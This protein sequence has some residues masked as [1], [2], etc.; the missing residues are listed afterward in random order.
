MAESAPAAAA[1]P[2][3]KK[4]ALV[5]VNK[6]AYTSSLEASASDPVAPG[7]LFEGPGEILA[8]QGEHAQL[9][10]CRPV[11]DVWLRLDQLEAMPDT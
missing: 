3:L 9:H 5:R 4:G 8:I 2:S 11:P 10:W 1:A 7:Y 6:A